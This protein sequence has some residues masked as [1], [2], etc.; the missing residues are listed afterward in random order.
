V[1]EPYTGFVPVKTNYIED[2]ILPE[3]QTLANMG[4]EIMWCD[5]GGPNLTAEFAADWFNK[6][7]AIGR[8]VVIDSRCGLPGD[9]DTPEYARYSAYVSLSYGRRVRNSPK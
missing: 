9:F 1:T 3:M 8:Q 2:V 5:I 4:T 6:A 7:G